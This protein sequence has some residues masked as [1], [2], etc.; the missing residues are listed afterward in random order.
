MNPFLC[1]LPILLFIQYTLDELHV[2]V[3]AEWAPGLPPEVIDCD[4]DES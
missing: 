2:V 1:S 3:V 4:L